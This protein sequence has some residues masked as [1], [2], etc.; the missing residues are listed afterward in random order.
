MRGKH[1]KAAA[2]RRDRAELE[3]RADK[4]EQRA[5]RLEKD[6]A[7]LRESSQR[8]I[9]GLRSELS[10]ALKARDQAA[11]PAVAEAERKIRELKAERD[12][13]CD[14]LKSIQ[15]KWNTLG[16][17]IIGLLQ[18][19][20]LKNTEAIEVLATACDPD[21]GMPALNWGAEQASKSSVEAV[22]TIQRAR[23]QRSVI[24]PISVQEA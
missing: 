15:K 8:Q 12:A 5:D 4:A 24:D 1:A 10:H 3:Q 14:K 20:G 9:S 16:G 19:M 2:N 18:G 22:M 11:S 23:G 6:L 13:A 17:N 7:E 21:K